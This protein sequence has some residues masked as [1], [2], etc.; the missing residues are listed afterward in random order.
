MGLVSGFASLRCVWG[1]LRVS[2]F[3]FVSGVKT[4]LIM[5]LPW[6]SA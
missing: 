2:F 5:C 4:C 6:K 3:V 1:V